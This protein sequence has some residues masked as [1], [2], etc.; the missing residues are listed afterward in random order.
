M[1]DYLGKEVVFGV[2][3]EDIYDRQH[4][5]PGITAAPLMAKVDVTESMGNEIFVP[6]DAAE[7]VHCAG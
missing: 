7:D 4:A 6:A 5:P 3:P 2:R 1:A